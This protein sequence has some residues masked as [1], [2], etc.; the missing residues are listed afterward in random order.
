MCAPVSIGNE[1]C[2]ISGADLIEVD[3]QEPAADEVADVENGRERQEVAK[4]LVNVD[5]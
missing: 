2:H 1:I 4:A 5:S 3:V